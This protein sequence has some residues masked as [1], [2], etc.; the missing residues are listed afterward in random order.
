MRWLAEAVARLIGSR[1]RR[2][3]VELKNGR[4][5]VGSIR[6][7]DALWR[8]L[9]AASTYSEPPGWASSIASPEVFAAL[10][11]ELDLDVIAEGVS[12]EQAQPAQSHQRVPRGIIA[13]IDVLTQ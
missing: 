10:P 11:A 4:V 9:R 3:H 7:D 2:V 8:R 12:A 1:R 6:I 13:K 5:L